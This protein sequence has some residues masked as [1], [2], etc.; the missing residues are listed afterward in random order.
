M[1]VFPVDGPA[2]GREMHF[3]P[4]PGPPFEHIAHPQSTLQEKLICHPAR[5]RVL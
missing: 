5:M 4:P 2:C 3:Q 1:H